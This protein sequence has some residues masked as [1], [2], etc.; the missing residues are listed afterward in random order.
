M[1]FKFPSLFSSVSLKT[2]WIIDYIWDK[3]KNASK[4]EHFNLSGSL[5]MV[6]AL[7]YFLITDTA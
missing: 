1:P 7:I 4:Y 3:T 5:I 6:I 2:D